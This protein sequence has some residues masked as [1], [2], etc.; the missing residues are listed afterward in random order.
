[1]SVNDVSERGVLK[2]ERLKGNNSYMNYINRNKGG[3]EKLKN[4]FKN[5]FGIKNACK[6]VKESQ[7]I[8]M[9]CS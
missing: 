9:N 4:M 8:V 7:Q 6:N 2:G 3:A 1:M 5:M